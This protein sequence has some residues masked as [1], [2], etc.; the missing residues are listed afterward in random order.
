MTGTDFAQLL[1]PLSGQ[2]RDQALLAHVDCLVPWPLVP[3]RYTRAGRV[4]E[5]QVTSDVLAMGTLDDPFR[6]PMGAPAVQAF[7]DHLGLRPITRLVSDAVWAAASVRLA[8]HPMSFSRDGG[9]WMLSSACFVEHNQHVE[10]ARRGRP[11]L[12]AG[13]KKDV[14]L[15]SEL[16]FR[17][18]KVAIYGWHLLNGHP[19]QPL[20]ASTHGAVY[21]DYS[22]GGRLMSPVVLI[23]G[24]EHDIDAVLADPRRA[25][26][27]T[28]DAAPAA[29]AF[30]RYAVPSWAAISTAPTE[31]PPA[32]DDAPTPDGSGDDGLEDADLPDPLDLAAIDQLPAR[33]FTK[34]TRTTARLLV[35]HTTES[36]CAPGVARNVAA[37][38]GG[39]NAPQ[40]SAHYIVGPDATIQGVPLACVAWAAPGAN[41]DGVQIEQTGWARFTEAEW[42]GEPQQAM[43]ERVAQLL[44]A[45]CRHFNLPAVFLDAESLKRGV[46]GVTTHV[47]VNRAYRKS[48][49][50]DCGPAY[51]METVLRRVRVLLRWG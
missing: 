33:N 31:P 51:P 38:F 5:V 24:E 15:C 30:R 25:P 17:A 29:L 41:S 4:I 2:A 8:P 48:T 7:A 36:P 27:L 6:L 46:R 40:A 26:L 19:I 28:G 35:L 23:D 45:L 9:R 44:A 18:D 13:H 32:I 50:T 14:V 37:W 39:P 12:I 3:V 22:H 21:C 47:E 10:E 20:N 42:N 43:L 49:H 1:L 16:A 34:A 11:G